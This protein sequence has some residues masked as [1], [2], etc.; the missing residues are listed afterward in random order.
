MKNFL[1]KDEG[2][3]KLLP[4]LYNWGEDMLNN[5]KIFK[6]LGFIYIAGDRK[7]TSKKDA[8]D[9]VNMSFVASKNL[10]ESGDGNDR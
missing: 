10:K 1:S 5:V 3:A 8:E 4:A 9:Y 2:Y 7:F 6:E